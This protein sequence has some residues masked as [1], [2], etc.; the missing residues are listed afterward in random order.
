LIAA[1]FAPS[2]AMQDR[3]LLA[4][5]FAGSY[6][7]L[8]L[9]FAA[10][11]AVLSFL[12]LPGPQQLSDWAVNN[13]P[14]KELLAEP[15]VRVAIFAGVAGYAAMT[16]LMTAAPI[17]IHVIEGHSV[18]EAA[19]VIRAHIV[20]MF[21]PSLVSGWLVRQ[22]GERRLIWCGIV[23]QVLC[24]LVAFSGRE[25]ADYQV[26]L[27]LLGFGW[28]L[29]FVGGTTMLVRYAPPGYGGIR[30]QGINEFAVFGTMAV[31]ALLAGTL[32][33]TLGWVATNAVALGLLV[34]LGVLL[35]YV[36]SEGSASRRPA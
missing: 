12:P 21:L 35:S 17:S 19:G 18:D 22:V 24:V 34:L 8:T 31:A 32:M 15:R 6:G 14:V 13:S 27:V 30:I 9:L 26:A 1:I 16:L 7:A 10:T 20:A 33:H 29:L 4:T 11:I 2:L 36:K 5:E 25:L 3:Y 23:L 28:N